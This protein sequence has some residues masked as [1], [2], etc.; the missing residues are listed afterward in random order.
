MRVVGHPPTYLFGY[1]S[2]EPIRSTFSTVAI[3][4][5]T[6]MPQIGHERADERKFSFFAAIVTL[7]CPGLHRDVLLAW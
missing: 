1:L 4:E 6:H 7:L 5:R 3:N 2:S